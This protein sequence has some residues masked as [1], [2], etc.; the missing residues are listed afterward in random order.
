MRPE[1]S[2]RDVNRRRFARVGRARR[3]PGPENAASWRRWL[4]WLATPFALLALAAAAFVLSDT[5][6]FVP[7]AHAATSSVDIVVK[8]RSTTLD[9]PAFKWMINLDNSHDNTTVTYPIKSSSPVIAFGDET[10][11]TGIV[12]EDT[13]AAVGPA[14]TGADCDNMID[15]DGDTVADDGCNRGYLVTI[16]ANDGVGTLNPID[17]KV[18]GVVFRMPDLDGEV[19]VELEPNP[20]PLS[21]VRARV[22]HDNLSV[23]N[24]EDVPV[25]EGLAGFNVVLFDRVGHVSVDWFGNPL[26]TQ[27]YP[28]GVAPLFLAVD[29]AGSG[30]GVD[31]DGS[32]V[33]VPGTG[34][35][36]LSDANGDVVIKNLGPNKY[37][38]WAIPPDGEG[39]IQTSTI[40]GKHDFDVWLDEGNSG[41]ATDVAFNQNYAWFGFV[42]PCAFGD[43]TDDCTTATADT[44]GD[45]TI[46]GLVRGNSGEV[47]LNLGQPVP[48][49][50]LALNNIGGDD[51]QVWTGRGNPDGTF[52]IE[53]VPPGHYQLVIWDLPQDYIIQFLTV[54]T[55]EDTCAAP[56]ITNLGDVLV[57]YW[58]GQ[59]RGSV[60]LDANENGIRDPGE[61][62]MPAYD[63][64]I[65]FKDGSIYQAGL[66]DGQ[67][68]YVFDE[69]F[70]FTKFLVSE[71]GYGRLKH[72]GAAA[73]ATD[74]MGDPLNYPWTNDC[75]D[76]DGNAVTPCAPASVVRECTD[77]A[78]WR[79]C[80]HG[81][82]NQDAGL[83]GL[84]QAGIIQA[85]LSLYIDWGKSNHA[86]GA[87]GGI[88]GI[89]F[90]STTRNELE[91]RFQA[92]EDFE[93]GVANATIN[94]YPAV[95]DPLTGQPMYDDG[96]GGT[97]EV[98]KGSLANTYSA[99]SWDANLPKD[100]QPIGTIGRTPDQ[101]QPYPQIWDQC[102]ELIALQNQTRSGVFDGGYAF[103]E[104]CTAQFADPLAACVPLAS[105]Y[106]V[107]EA[108]GPTGY[109]V[110]KEEDINVFDGDDFI[111]PLVPPAACGGVKHM[112][113]VVDN[114]A[115]ANFDPAD[116]ANTQG[117][118][119]PNF[120]ATPSDL[121]PLGG[122]MFEGQR[123]PLC[124]QKVVKVG[125]GV[126]AAADFHMFTPVTLPGRLQG[127][128]TD[129]L[130][131]QFDP[132]NPQYGDKVGIPRVPIGIR[133][134]TG[135]L[136]QT[137]YTDD[138]G[139]FEALL[140]SSG[141]INCATPSGIC[142][143]MYSVVGNDPG[144][145]GAPNAGWNPNYGTLRL[146]YEVWPGLTT[147]ADVAIFPITGF[148]ATPNAEQGV[149]TVCGM[150]ATTP[151]VQY[152]SQPYAD[153]TDVLPDAISIYGAGFGAIQNHGMVTLDGVEL[154]AT[155]WSDTAITVSI[156]AGAAVGPRQL[157]VTNDLGVTSPSGI[158]VHVLDAGY[159]PPQRHVSTDL[160]HYQTIQAAIDAAV[161][162]DLILVHPGTYYETI[163]LGKNVKL[164]GYGVGATNNPTAGI[165]S[166][167]DNRFFGLGGMTAD[168]FYAKVAATPHD[169]PVTVPLGQAITV[170]AQ[171]GAFG[172]AFTTQIDGV[173]IRGGQRTEGE[174]NLGAIQGGGIYAHAYAR[175]LQISNT[176]IQSNSGV[177]GG[178]VILGQ[179]YTP[180]P[181][182]GG[183]SDNENDSVRLHHNRVLNNG[184]IMSAG[185]VG[186]FNGAEGFQIDHN[187][188]CGNYSAEYG[189]GISN[190]GFS[191]GA[192][193][194]NEVLFNEAFD[195]GGGI[196]IAGE[197]N[198]PFVSPGTGDID[199]LRNRIQSNLTNDDG[200]GVRLLQS[201]NGK[202]RIIDN[203]IVNNLA[204]DTGAVSLD[205][206][207]D[208]EIINNTV[209][210]N[211]ST[212]TSEDADRIS[213][214]VPL[215]PVNN[216][217]PHGAGLVS[218]AHSAALIAATSCVV[219]CFSDPVLFNNIFWEND[220][221]H[222]D[223]TQSLLGTP[224]P[225][226]G[227]IDLEI[228]VGGESFNGTYNVCT[229]FSAH[230]L[231]DGTNS[232]GDP[233]FVAPISSAFQALAFAGDPA[234]VTVLLQDTPGSPQGN[235]HLTGASPAID[236]G[237]DAVGLVSAP[238]DDFD[239]Q[240]RPLDPNGLGVPFKWD[241]GA[242]EVPESASG[243][244]FSAAVSTVATD[245][246]APGNP[247]STTVT[248][249]IGAMTDTTLSIVETSAGG[250]PSGFNFLGQQA[251]ISVAP[252]TIITS[253][254]T[255]EF[256][257]DGALVP[258]IIADVQIF[259]NG[260]PVPD[261]PGDPCIVSR[262]QA[263]GPGTPL[264]VTVLTSG[265]SNWSLGAQHGV[266]GDANC[267]GQV[268]MGDA[269]LIAR[270]NVGLDAS[271]PCPQ[272][273]NVNGGAV[274]TSNDIS[275]GDALLIG[276]AVVGLG[277][278]P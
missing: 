233:L 24:A 29:P 182:A 243:P 27:Y 223:G 67:G 100:C 108:V 197:L 31:V 167:I 213:C 92:N 222:L 141:T 190:F 11:A 101:V 37:T 112:V 73:Y 34:G 9:V 105:G 60:Y 221:F 263:G 109:E 129:D 90:N 86:P 211:V 163:V 146:V 253:P 234:L 241:I 202:I 93:P 205:D 19:V 210:R 269:L 55:R 262:V 229:A 44:A 148:V 140:P 228:G 3:A 107:V 132:A 237:T 122:S 78:D 46:T 126:N 99:D 20:L 192:I 130:H 278:L 160:L 150:P 82:I 40:E 266:H 52:A 258:S 41:Y 26:C 186:I 230:C 13:P 23:N 250:A 273:A 97:G 155:A 247:L 209:A 173:A 256:T 38:L 181:T 10:N 70:P 47:D 277:S 261:C 63:V 268:T 189:G 162:G 152:V 235:Y 184:G 188:I 145:P 224:L 42:R 75:T 239:S 102:I 6:S 245:P 207:L 179:A 144:E 199:I 203:I 84:L 123:M 124:D 65:R 59:Q 136:L 259:R 2:F 149:S 4:R 39:W 98:L 208:V 120:A 83:A 76:I 45:G 30:Y 61:L 135:Q 8:D 276:R 257:I 169:G 216:S 94:L 264:V 33:P 117:V 133:D 194:D 158:T 5:G 53:D 114:P 113:D 272:N 244:V 17:Y 174:G 159:N 81:P 206:A 143:N 252:G 103:E 219:R 36:C 196:M 48:S 118:Y 265:F 225:S 1:L 7:R 28:P 217:C 275:M 74:A 49:P 238:A 16:Q 35:I 110:V 87:N 220:A 212:A 249:P 125:S 106:W 218:A 185:G 96:I 137:V 255:V 79:T 166:L 85:G 195:E 231:L 88:A 251:N 142:A 58:F 68:N 25:E 270:Y 236:A 157:L 175:H 267:D 177:R 153:L 193:T 115:D 164:Q 80:E 198:L 271:L 170:L 254:V 168:E 176:L 134:Y 116:P 151:D 139:Y 201:V 15:D 14:E 171:D 187:V 215:S 154:L 54:D 104:D 119:N 12:L 66:A 64:D 226:G 156:P 227:S 138:G 260:A 69:I 71:V 32:Y 165:G 200:S 191:S 240:P 183:A 56:C 274:I 51:E 121:A 178:G 172:P 57:P 89:V 204:T 43:L 128:L 248:V 180:N 214:D 18:S 131:T 72:T 127:L 232:I 95:I 246:L 62:P 147:N 22:F 77:A 50:Y 242:D 111:A 161:D 21:Q 91:A